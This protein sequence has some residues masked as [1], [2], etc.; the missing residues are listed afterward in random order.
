VPHRSGPRKKGTAQP[1]PAADAEVM[2]HVRALGLESV[3]AYRAWCREH[4]FDP[5]VR[6]SWQE[7]REERL[8]AEKAEA[9]V[10][11]RADLARHLHALGLTSAEEYA[12]WCRAHGF[13]EALQKS[14]QQRRQEQLAMERAKSQAALAAAKRHTRRPHDTIRRIADG[15]IDPAELPSPSLRKIHDAFAAVEGEP[16]V[17][18]A[19]LR[20]LLHAQ[21]WANLLGI[22][23]VIALYGEQPRNTFIDGLLALARHH[24]SWLR[25][26]DAWRPDS[27]NARR[28]FGSLARHLLACYPVPPFM[29]AAWFGGETP[30]ARQQQGW[31]RHIGA[32]RNI[33]AADLPLP[34]T[35]MMAHHF[36]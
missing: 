11:A 2:R 1:P 22:E 9:A 4:G 17:R 20:L 6:K 33:R 18:D 12:T 27:H 14:R 28:Q 15:E 26:A 34:L 21:Q 31:F 5:T 16:D 19:F 29:D 8:A 32:G 36:L 30:R 25:P 35:R 3:E 10:A 24:E 23:P 13:S 7:R